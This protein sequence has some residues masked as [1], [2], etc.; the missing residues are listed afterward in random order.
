MP[1]NSRELLL[2]NKAANAL[3]ADFDTQVD[4]LIRTINVVDNQHEI[5]RVTELMDVYEQK[6][7]KSDRRRQKRRS[8]VI[9]T[10]RPFEFLTFRN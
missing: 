6:R 9:T 7:A 1:N 2:T 4:K 5:E 3:Q 10:S 8:M